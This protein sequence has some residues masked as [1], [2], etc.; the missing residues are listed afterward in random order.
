MAI[1]LAK[2]FTL[3]IYQIDDGNIESTF[4]QIERPLY[5]INLKETFKFDEDKSIDNVANK[6]LFGVKSK[7]FI[8]YGP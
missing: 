5:E 6:M 7:Y 2:K 1:Y 3:K 4:D 8:I